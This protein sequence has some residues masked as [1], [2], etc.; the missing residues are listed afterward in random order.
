MKR[1]RSIQLTRLAATAAVV[2][3]VALLAALFHALGPT[4]RHPA[5]VTTQHATVTDRAPTAAA[6]A[7]PVFSGPWMPVPAFAGGDLPSFAPSDPRIV[8]RTVG[9]G[10]CPR[11]SG[12]PRAE[13]T[14]DDGAH[15]QNIPLPAT[16]PGVNPSGAGGFPVGYR[17]IASPLDP[18]TVF[19]TVTIPYPTTCPSWPPEKRAFAGG[20]LFSG[21][22]SCSYEYRSSDAGRHW[23]QVFLP[24]GGQLSTPY[25]VGGPGGRQPVS[26]QATTLFALD[27]AD[28]SPSMETDRLI[29]STNGGMTWSLAD[30]A[31]A[32]QGQTVFDYVA[33]PSGGPIFAATAPERDVPFSLW[34]SDDAGTSW[35]AVGTLPGPDAGGL[36]LTE[37]AGTAAP[38]LYMCAHTVDGANTPATGADFR[39]S[40]DGGQSWLPAPTTGLPSAGVEP[41][42]LATLADGS[43]VVQSPPSSPSGPVAATYYAWKL[44]QPEWRKLTPPITSGLL[45]IT[46]PSAN[47]P[48]TLWE[49]SID[50]VSAS[51]LVAR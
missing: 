19:L 3:V 21:F 40:Q 17:M 39:F 18:F 51:R 12:S 43:V 20:H 47:V 23:R 22:D 25:Q 46:P 1:T 8:Y 35:Q 15:W 24:A 28:G 45:I 42:I 34:R 48:E 49:F 11:C 36:A 4:S 29:R 30:V 10:G 37:P 38:L 44:G 16:P 9:G 31:L 2:T 14:D 27:M 32:R 50:L 5:T 13:W 6:T 7:A 41:A 26:A 33:A